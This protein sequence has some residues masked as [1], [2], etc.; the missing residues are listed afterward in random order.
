MAKDLRDVEFKDYSAKTV[1][2]DGD[3]HTHT[4]SVHVATKDTAEILG[5]VLTHSGPHVV[6]Q[7]DVLVK[8]ERPD[9]YDVHSSKVWDEI[10]YA[11]GDGKSAPVVNDDSEND[12]NRDSSNA[13]DSDSDD[14]TTPTRN[15]SQTTESK[16]VAKTTATK[17]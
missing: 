15:P 3:E 9:F 12:D 10:G 13:A 14:N 8:T 11:E 4:A 2:D 1:D 7:G 6:R 5:T 17:R 16:T